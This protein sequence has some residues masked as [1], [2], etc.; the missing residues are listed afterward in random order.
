M[1]KQVVVIIDANG[2]VR[3]MVDTE[4]DRLCADIGPRYST[5][6]ASHVESWDDLSRAA[7]NWLYD[8]RNFDP[9]ILKQLDPNRFWADL[10]ISGGPV[11]GPFDT[12]DEAVHAEI[13]WLQ[14][15]DLPIK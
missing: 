7:K 14:K 11:L 8:Y 3:R 2:M 12:Y 4:S 13:A 10:L 1:T 9:K 15:H 5:R 6:R